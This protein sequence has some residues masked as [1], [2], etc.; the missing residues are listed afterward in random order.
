MEKSAEMTVFLS[1]DRLVA[2]F[3]YDPALV[4]VV[5]EIPGR[6]WNP[7][8]RV[9]SWPASP[10][11]ARRLI[12]ILGRGYGFDIHQNVFDLISSME[13]RVE[14]SR[15]VS[16]PVIPGLYP[17]QAAAVEFAV[18][19]GGRVLIGDEMGIGKTVEG[20]AV[21]CRFRSFPC[22]VVCPASVKLHWERH[23]RQWA[24][25]DV[26]VLEGRGDERC[27][28]LLE[29]S[30]PWIVT[31]YEIL[32]DHLE[33]ILARGPKA[34]IIDEATFIKNPKAARSKSVAALCVGVPTI[35]ALDG[36]PLPNRP[37]ELYHLLHLINPSRWPDFFGFAFRFCAPV[38]GKWGWSFDGAANLQELQE[39]LR[40]SVMIRRTKDQVLT[41][42][43]EK[44]RTMLPVDIDFA[45][46]AEADDELTSA[47][48]AAKRSH[49]PRARAAAL[50][51][52]EA[53]RRVAY[54][55]KEAAVHEWIDT[56]L[57]SGRPL[58]VFAHHRQVAASIAKKHG[59]VLYSGER[60]Q[61]QRDDA[62]DEFQDGKHQLIVLT[63][64]AGGVG[65]TLNRAQECLF[66]EEPW[67]WARLEQAEDR[68][69]RIG[70][71]GAV[72]CTHLFARGT[73]EEE[74]L[75][76]LEKKRD[77][78]LAALDVADDL[79]EARAARE[80]RA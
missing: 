31:N 68:L 72:N 13:K 40:S 76:L 32:G 64:D 22:V 70:Q 69:H 10:V 54:K 63:V 73:V 15:S 24:H 2:R 74:I 20:I 60:T 80:E 35:V 44:T 11:L 5:K 46:Y 3:P 7:P 19:V 33:R 14:L 4:K 41:D 25:D 23:I 52:V 29:R 26:V 66:V 51:K 27:R 39:E 37:V 21:V 36:T 47:A 45:R 62:V 30:V 16:G 56:F 65:I 49:D 6:R 18:E 58:A 28:A 38:K 50:A 77:V 71:K 57:R 79:I 78:G 61:S 55:A 12:E 67:T 43:P 17:F 1:G 75:G 59:G 48:K 42:L 9:W 34:V 53:L 8:S